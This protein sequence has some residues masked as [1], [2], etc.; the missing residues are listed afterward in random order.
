MDKLTIRDIR[1]RAVMVPLRRPL[2]SASGAIPTAP[3]VLID[4][5]TEQGITGRSYLFAFMPGMLKPIVGC[6]EAVR[7]TL[8][9]DALAPLDNEQKLRKRFTLFDTPGVLGLAI[10]GVDM[11]AWDALAIAQNVP[12]VRLLGGQ[13]R[14]VRAYNSC[15]LWIQP[16]DKL[17]DEAEALAA[18]GGFGAVKLRLG[19]DNPD[20]DLAAVRAVKKRMG[21]RV[22]LMCD[23]NQR[24]TVNEAILRGRMLDDEGLYW[25]EEP[26]R[27]DDFAGHAR[28]AAAARTPIQLGENWWGAHDM[29]KSVAAA[30]SDHA[31]FDAMKIGGVSG[32]LRAAALAESSGLP[33]SS[34]AFPELSAQLLAVTPTCHLLEYA[35]G[36]GSIALEPLWIEDG[37][38]VI[39]DRP[40]SG[41]EWDEDALARATAGP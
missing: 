10:A 1:A 30:A 13:V 15:G 3:L 34:H 17:P 12:L 40:G 36:A 7:D 24:L 39:D 9:G 8:K 16:I 22:T 23:F 29:E 32:W 2:V 31:M 33:A 11:C 14:P 19:R 4:L 41:L 26:T 35:G 21:G 6:I 27:A 18:E 25:I 28:I 38:A 20:E 5:E 37:H